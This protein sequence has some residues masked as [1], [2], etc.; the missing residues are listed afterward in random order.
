MG[1][2]GRNL[3]PGRRGADRPIATLRVAPVRS[4]PRRGARPTVLTWR[5]PTRAL[6]WRGARRRPRARPPRHRSAWWQGQP[7]GRGEALR[8]RPWRGSRSTC[9][10]GRVRFARAPAAGL[11][12]LRDGARRC[13]VAP[14]REPRNG[15]DALIACQSSFRALFRKNENDN[16]RNRKQRSL[17]CRSSAFRRRFPSKT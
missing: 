17:T 14:G 10:T 6:L 11:L 13:A 4:A 8:C 5:A 9:G 16:Q 2:G 12:V 15:N 1:R 7:A 3:M